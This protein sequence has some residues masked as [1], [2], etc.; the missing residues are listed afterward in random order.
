MDEGTVCVVYLAGDPRSGMRAGWVMG[1]AGHA[2]RRSQSAL[3]I[4]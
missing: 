2:R 3:A 4:A 1:I